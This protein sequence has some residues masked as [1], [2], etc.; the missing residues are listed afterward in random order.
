MS[1]RFLAFFCCF[2]C[3]SPAAET[4]L[5]GPLL[6]FFFDP[7]NGLQPIQG[8]SG[9]LTVGEPANLKDDIGKVVISPRQDYA[10]AVDS[11]NLN[12]LRSLGGQISISPLEIQ[13]S[14]IDLIGLSPTGAV[15]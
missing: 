6:G 4:E 8:V 10:L 9:A 2:L 11:S 5:G 13:I 1:I 7:T 3:H 15:A 12:L 14:G